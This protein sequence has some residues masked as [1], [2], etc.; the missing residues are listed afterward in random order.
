MDYGLRISVISFAITR[1][2]SAD[3]QTAAVCDLVDVFGLHNG[4]L[5]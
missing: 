4:D 3:K 2:L 1:E 5:L